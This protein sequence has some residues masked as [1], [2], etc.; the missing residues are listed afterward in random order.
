VIND[1]SDLYATAREYNATTDDY[2]STFIHYDITGGAFTQLATYNTS[3]DL[4]DA[5][6]SEL[7]WMV[8]DNETIYA[9]FY[10]NDPVLGAIPRDFASQTTWVYTYNSY[11]NILVDDTFV[12]AP[13]SGEG[14]GAIDKF[15][16]STL[17]YRGEFAV[18]RQDGTTVLDNGFNFAAADWTN[19][20]IYLGTDS[21][22]YEL[23]KV[24]PIDFSVVAN[25]TSNYA[26]SEG[27]L[28]FIAVNSITGQV[29]VTDY[30][31]GVDLAEYGPAVLCPC[32][33]P[34]TTAVPVANAVAGNALTQNQAVGIGVGVAAFGVILIIVVVVLLMRKAP[35][36][37]QA[38]ASAEPTQ[39]ATTA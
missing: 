31:S 27:D 4:G 36:G 21:E 1:G 32:A 38:Q 26:N 3:A 6:L 19:G 20:F 29:F 33:A 10:N 9:F 8:L 18:V 28:N 34:N 24:S 11:D 5:Q 25:V 12:Y 15:S 2:Y 7:Y 16:K 39:S 35:G 13:W 14:F 23:F 30:D 37:D 22:P 17:T